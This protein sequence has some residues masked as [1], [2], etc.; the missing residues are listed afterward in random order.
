MKRRA[1]RH[2]I[3]LELV[4]ANGFAAI[5]ELA[6]ACDISGQT[7]RRDLSEL[8]AQGLIQKY[9][10]GAS[11]AGQAPK[12][13]YALRSATHV[14]EKQ[15]VARLVA[16]LV[17]DDASLY[18]AGG[19]T[20]ALVA[21]ELA[22]RNRL[23]IVTN[24][25]QAGLALYENDTLRV[26]V[27]GGMIRSESGSLTGEDTLKVIRR[28][29]LDFAIISASGI[30][31]DGT[32]LERDQEVV[33]PITEMSATSRKVILA[34]DGSKFSDVGTIKSGWIGDVDTLVCDVIPP[35]GI[36]R[37]CKENNVTVVTPEAL[38]EGTALT[39]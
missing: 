14:E 31:A 30:T 27:A 28:F 16:R 23:F 18:L 36:L 5:D 35:A 7:V 20:L 1:E 2:E 34:I 8:E 9:H 39:S 29:M 22:A 38:S 15:I 25:L 19:S 26:M 10:G 12:P 24:N 37:L 3:I 33:A 4:R 32:I 17:N 21:K 13:S 6:R 11:W